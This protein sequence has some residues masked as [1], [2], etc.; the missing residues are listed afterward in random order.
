ME[1]L[2]LRRNAE[3]GSLD[4][5]IQDECCAGL[6][7]APGAVAAVCHEEGGEDFI[8][9]GFAGAVALHWRDACWG[10]HY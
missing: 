2:G 4:N 9:D 10:R 8:R 6:A 7:L 1:R 3:V 5:R